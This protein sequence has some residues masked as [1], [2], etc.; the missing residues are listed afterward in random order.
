[1]DSQFAEYISLRRQLFRTYAAAVPIAIA[2][3]AVVLGGA[4]FEL[5]AQPWFGI[6]AIAVGC[7]MVVAAARNGIAWYR[8]M[9]WP[10]PRCDKLFVVAWYSS[11]PTNECKHCGLKVESP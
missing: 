1:M 6:V 3:A 7:V 9:S 11:W 2:M 5:D 8:L 4:F 10:C